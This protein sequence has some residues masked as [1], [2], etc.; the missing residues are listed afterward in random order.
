[1]T[2]PSRETAREWCEDAAMALRLARDLVPLLGSPATLDRAR[3]QL[4]R[5]LAHRAQ[6]FLDA[7]DATIFGHPRSPYRRLL[8]HAGCERGDLRAL[9]A[10]EGL[11]GTLGLLAGQGV[12]ITVDEFAGRR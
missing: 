12:Y 3:R 7:A 5:R 11:E 8:A 4:Q 1:M 6:G 2:L 9:V 10:R